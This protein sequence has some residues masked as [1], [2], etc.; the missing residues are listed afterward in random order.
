MQTSDFNFELPEH[1][2]AQRPAAERSGSRL[3]TLNR[4]DKTLKHQQ[5]ASLSD[6]LF[7]G[8]LLVV[9]N[10][11]VIP[12]RLFGRKPETGGEVEMLLYRQVALNDWWAMARPGKRIRPG[13][14]VEVNNKAGENSGIEAVA[15]EKNEEGHIRFQFRGVPDIMQELEHLGRLPLPPYIQRQDGNEPEDEDRYQTVYSK[16]PG[17]VA[18]PTAG[19][20]F[21]PELLGA[22]TSKGVSIAEVTLHVGL[23][24]FTPVKAE[25]L[26]D[27]QMHMEEYEISPEVAETV[28]R[29]KR[30]GRRVIAIGTTSTRVLE[31]AADQGQPILP[32]KG[33]TAKF[34][35][36]P[37][38]FKIVD[39][40]VTNFHLPGSTL[41]MLASAFAEP[42]GTGGR[43]FILNAYRQAVAE[44]Y[45]FF[46][47]GDAMFIHS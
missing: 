22:L 3:M 37:Y 31:S 19:L 20:H 18:A 39:A 1:L 5:F 43:E 23:G 42:G 13:S 21:T 32:G 15:Q 9:N 45:R 34:I 30:E 6:Y 29:A 28:N 26:T 36:P 10:S 38:R 2:I 8:D 17:S 35:Y 33:K 14:V 16:A 12:A 47:Y 11:R 27:H 44:K 24:T 46:S 40:L 25:R 41:L 7:A 4:A